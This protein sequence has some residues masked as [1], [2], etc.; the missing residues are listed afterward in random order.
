MILKG[1]REEK[2]L[3]IAFPDRV[4]VLPKIWHQPKE[5]TRGKNIG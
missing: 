3:G 1:K 4:E 2:I 5:E